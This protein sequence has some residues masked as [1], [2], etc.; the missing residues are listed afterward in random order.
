M[1]AYYLAMLYVCICAGIFVISQVGA[2][3]DVMD[4]T[5][6]GGIFNWFEGAG[7]EGVILAGLLFGGSVTAI[8]WAMYSAN[9]RLIGNQGGTSQGVGIVVF[10]TLFWGAF[11]LAFDVMRTIATSMEGF[12][13]F[14][15]VFFAISILV[16]V[17]GLVQLSSSGVKSHG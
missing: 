2:F 1:N 16:F 10:G 11:L 5:F 15:V 7:T 13:I 14:N 3:G 4:E 12:Y 17:M 8:A 6:V 9:V